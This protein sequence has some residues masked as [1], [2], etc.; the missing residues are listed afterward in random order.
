MSL[1]VPRSI[2]STKDSSSITTVPTSSMGNPNIFIKVPLFFS[3][4]TSLSSTRRSLHLSRMLIP[5]ALSSVGARKLVAATPVYAVA[6]RRWLHDRSSSSAYAFTVCVLPAPPPP[7]RRMH[8]PV[9]TAS[10]AAAD[11]SAAVLRS[12]WR[13]FRSTE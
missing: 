9:S 1:N 6:T 12:V 5:K 4:S 3:F 10:F 13:R 11:I 8:C 2:K 7:R